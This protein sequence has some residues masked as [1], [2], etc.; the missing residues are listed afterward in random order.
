MSNIARDLAKQAVDRLIAA[1]RRPIKTIY[2]G[3]SEWT[4][5]YDGALH[6]N[7]SVRVAGDKIAVDLTQVPGKCTPNHVLAAT[8]DVNAALLWA[9]K[10]VFGITL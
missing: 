8:Q 5:G 6:I 10:R 7:I 2:Y 4:L 9:T 1:A 3:T